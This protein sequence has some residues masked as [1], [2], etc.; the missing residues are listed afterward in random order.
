M[1]LIHF[2]YKPPHLQRAPLHEH[3][4]FRFVERFRREKAEVL[5]LAGTG[6]TIDDEHVPTHPLD[7]RAHFIV[8]VPDADAGRVRRQM[9]QY[10][11]ALY[12]TDVEFSNDVLE[13][14]SSG[15]RF[16]AGAFSSTPAGPVFGVLSEVSEI[17]EDV[18]ELVAGDLDVLESIVERAQ[19][20]LAR[21]EVATATPG[22]DM[23]PAPTGLS[24]RL[25]A[26][27][28]GE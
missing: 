20:L 24:E 23:A 2:D 22:E 25:A 4:P 27:R 8:R 16:L 21:A 11:Y 17:A 26:L 1:A 14:L 3:R 9:A 12:K 7:P 18:P 6:A 19:A 5:D 28:G 10:V 13:G 15:L